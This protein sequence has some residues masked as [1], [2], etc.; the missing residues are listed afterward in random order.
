MRQQPLAISAMSIKRVSRRSADECCNLEWSSITYSTFSKDPVRSTFLK[1]VYNE[2]V[3]LKSLN[4]Q[5]KTG[6]LLAIMGP[7]GKS[8]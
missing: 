6:Q 4:G 5:A 1:P 2:K 7:T 8:L 3:I